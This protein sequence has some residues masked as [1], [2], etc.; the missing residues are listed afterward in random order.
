MSEKIE[1][2]GFNAFVDNAVTYA[3][4]LN[5]ELLII[6][7]TKNDK[8]VVGSGQ[9]TYDRRYALTG[10]SVDMEFIEESALADN[11]EDMIRDPAET[12]KDLADRL[13]RALP[14][15]E[16]ENVANRVTLVSKDL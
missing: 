2:Y 8:P 9:F 7:E 13:R 3:R 11:K 5:S 10:P 1:C 12:A 15:Y 6:I 4:D 16:I 14:T